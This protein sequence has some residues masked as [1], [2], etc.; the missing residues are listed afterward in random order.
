[1]RYAGHI[2]F[3]FLE[4]DFFNAYICTLHIFVDIARKNEQALDIIIIFECINIKYKIY[5]KKNFF[6]AKI[7]R[8]TFRAKMF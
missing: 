7:L 5:Q 8:L 4:G 1:M 3:D 6:S 2:A